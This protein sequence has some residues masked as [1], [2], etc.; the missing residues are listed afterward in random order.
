MGS[1][2]GGARRRI[3]VRSPRGRGPRGAGAR[4]RPSPRAGRRCPARAR[5]PGSGAR[6][7]RGCAPPRPPS[8]SRAGAANAPARALPARRRRCRPACALRVLLAHDLLE[9]RE[10][11][12]RRGHAAVDRALEQHLLDLLAGEAVRKR[13]SD[14]HCELALAVERDERHQRYGTSH[15]PVEPGSRPDLAPR[16]AGDQ[17]LEVRAVVRGTCDRAVDMVVSEHLA[18]DSHPFVTAHAAS[19]S[20][21]CSLTAA[22][23]TSGRST[24]AR[25][26]APA[27]TTSRASGIPWAS[28]SMSGGAVTGSA[29]PTTTRVGAWISPTRLRKSQRASASQAAA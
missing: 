19:W 12:V 4:R 18:A 6:R 14:V 28:S 1:R 7:T 25:W 21:R 2:S 20:A 22:E 10:R 5:L 3:A 29:A 9:D 24:L 16:V 15:T 23:N 13:R 11:A 26:A 17:V 27:R 8:R